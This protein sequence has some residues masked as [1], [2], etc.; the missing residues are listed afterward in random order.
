MGTV[1]ARGWNIPEEA[2]RIEPM[3]DAAPETAV[4]AHARLANAAAV[5][6]DG[7][8]SATEREPND[9]DHPQAVELPVTVTGQIAPAR[10]AD[11]FQ[12]PGKKGQALRFRVEARTLG[13]PLDPVLRVTDEAGKTLVEVD[14]TGKARD[15]E[16]TFTPPADGVYRV[17][18]RDLHGDGGGRYFYRLTAA[19]VRPDFSL[20][21]ADDRFTLAPGKPLKVPV[22]VDR[23]DG[24]DGTIEVRAE[25]LPDGVDCPP[26]RSEPKGGTARSVTL[27]LSAKGDGPRSAAIQVVGAAGGASKP[28]RV[29][30]A[31]FAP[32]T[33]RAWLTVLPPTSKK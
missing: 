17:Q 13:S 6:L 18:V 16:L 29:P 12:F 24:F 9:R 2:R 1:E 30:V 5:R 28:A 20:A 14:D 19:P 21:L 3:P 32:G 11:V 8:A 33:T 22:K 15:A 23:K 26:V 7:H 27:T 4:V 10:D 31:G 25:N